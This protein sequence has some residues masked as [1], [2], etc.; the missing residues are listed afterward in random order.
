MSPP[1]KMCVTSPSLAPVPKTYLVA[2]DVSLLDTFWDSSPSLSAQAWTQCGIEGRHSFLRLPPS[3]LIVVSLAPGN[4]RR[5]AA[6]RPALHGILTL[7][8]WH[9][10]ESM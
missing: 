2:W 1:T 3:Y 5:G 6:S 8:G 9:V 7:S 10:A 4:S